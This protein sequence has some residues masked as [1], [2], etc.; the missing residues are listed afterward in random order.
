MPHF[1]DTQDKHS[2][3]FDSFIIT[4]IDIIVFKRSEKS[5][6]NNIVNT[7]TSGVYRDLNLMI[8]KQFCS[9]IYVLPFF[10][11]FFHLLNSCHFIFFE[12]K[13]Y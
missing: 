13:S 8:L 7:S 11:S 12:N 10:Y 4:D 5:L 2:L 3:V 9:A 6:N 1:L